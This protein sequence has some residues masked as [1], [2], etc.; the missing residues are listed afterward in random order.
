[1]PLN[2]YIVLENFPW[3]SSPSTPPPAS[4][5]DFPL[6]RRPPRHRSPPETILD[7]LRQF[8]GRPVPL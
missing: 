6:A 2:P 8:R 1:M 4:P 3:F 7:L 5:G